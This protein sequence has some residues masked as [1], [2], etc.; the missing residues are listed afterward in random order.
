MGF[1]NNIFGGSSTRSLTEHE[2]WLLDEWYKRKV[3]KY[4]NA[5][6]ES[7]DLYNGFAGATFKRFM[8]QNATENVDV[9]RGDMERFLTSKGHRSNRVRG[10]LY[11]YGV[12]IVI[13]GDVSSGNF[14]T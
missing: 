7:R 9:S 4:E 12:R 11:F 3:A 2:Q 13:H 5:E 1:W 10:R 8:I 14:G 6:Q